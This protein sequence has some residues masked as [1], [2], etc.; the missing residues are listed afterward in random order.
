MIMV[1]TAGP[2]SAKCYAW[3]KVC[4][5]VYKHKVVW[6]WCK[7]SYGYKYQCKKKKLIKVGHKCHNKCVSWKPKH[8][9]TKKY[10]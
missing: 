3:K 7:N 8:H 5:P 2:A 6:G 1:G 4:K 10:Y 9:Y